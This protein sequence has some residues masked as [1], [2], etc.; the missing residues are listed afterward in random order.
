MH[1]QF[2]EEVREEK[3]SAQASCPPWVDPFVNQHLLPP[4]FPRVTVI[5]GRVETWD[6]LVE[7][8][9]SLHK[10]LGVIDCNGF[11]DSLDF[12]A[13]FSASKP[14]VLSR[15]FVVSAFIVCA[16]KVS[17]LEE[18]TKKFLNC[19]KLSTTNSEQKAAFFE[20]ANHVFAEVVH[21]FSFNRARLREKL[22]IIFE[23]MA[24][25]QESAEKL[26]RVIQASNGSGSS[27]QDKSSSCNAGTVTTWVLHHTLQLM[28]LYVL[29]GFE[30]NLYCP[31]EYRNIFWYL[32]E[33]LYKWTV[34]CLIT[35]SEGEGEGLDGFNGEI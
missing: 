25:L 15:A 3:E 32:E 1:A 4:T 8:V 13:D 16:M 14:C 6:R 7:L 23:E 11:D 22:P 5:P 12:L 2:G 18:A 10:A 30:L 24:Q 31:R 9:K 35:R 34:S 21:G 33:F 29:L 19:S 26:D 20:Q 27:G 17:A 28:A